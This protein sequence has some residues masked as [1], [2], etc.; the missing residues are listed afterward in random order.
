M[1]SAVAD[2]S[3]DESFRALRAYA[4]RTNTPLRTVA[5]GVVDRSLDVLGS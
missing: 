1:L 3:V 2:L 5:A 4:R